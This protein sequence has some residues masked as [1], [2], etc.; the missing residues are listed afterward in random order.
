MYVGQPK[1]PINASH[2]NAIKD[3]PF[4]RTNPSVLERIKSVAAVT[5]DQPG[6]AK[7]YK[8]TIRVADTTDTRKCPRDLKQV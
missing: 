4:V 8:E 7:L 2:G 6:P 1:C 3:R 5:G